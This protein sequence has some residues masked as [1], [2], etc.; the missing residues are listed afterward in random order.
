MTAKRIRNVRISTGGALSL[1]EKLALLGAFAWVV[2]TM[3][4]L[5]TQHGAN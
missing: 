5:I 1:G 4:M 3:V 2:Q